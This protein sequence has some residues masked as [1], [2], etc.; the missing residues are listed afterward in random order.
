M[1]E[2]IKN[3][4]IFYVS[5]S[6]LLHK[7][8]LHKFYLVSYNF[9]IKFLNRNLGKFYNTFKIEN[10]LILSNFFEGRSPFEQE[11]L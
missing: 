3:I 5:I 6:Q 1:S 2:T 4:Q 10:I 7:L 11:R 8:V 9:K